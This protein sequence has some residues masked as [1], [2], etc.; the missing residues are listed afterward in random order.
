[1][2]KHLDALTTNPARAEELPLDTKIQYLVAILDAI[3][4]ILEVK[5]PAEEES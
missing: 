5:Q 1:M 2:M 4:P 3:P